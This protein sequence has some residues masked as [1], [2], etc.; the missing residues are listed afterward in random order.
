[1]RRCYVEN[2]FARVSFLTKFRLENYQTQPLELFCKK[3]VLKNFFKFHRKTSVLESH[4]NIV[5]GLKEFFPNKV[6]VS[7][8]T[9][10]KE[11]L[12]RNF[13][14]IK[15]KVFYLGNCNGSL[16]LQISRLFPARSS[17]T[18]RQI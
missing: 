9:N 8:S 12:Q 5:A 11:F 10:K 18:F 7:R 1:M 13:L 15:F 3:R 2:I 16:K 14:E 17:L 6:R 4:F